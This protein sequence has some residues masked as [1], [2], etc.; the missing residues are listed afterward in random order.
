M[1]VLPGES[2]EE[3]AGQAAAEL[4]KELTVVGETGGLDVG[5]IV[6]AKIYLPI[7][8]AY[9]SVASLRKAVNAA[10]VGGDGDGGAEADGGVAVVVPVLRVGPNAAESASLLCIE[11]FARK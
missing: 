3:M 1:E 7:S 9:A 10:F 6:A 4:V 5:D 8:S 11:L 2:L